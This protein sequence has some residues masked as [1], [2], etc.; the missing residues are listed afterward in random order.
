MCGFSFTVF[1]S[2]FQLLP[3]A[4]Y[5]ILELGRQ[6]GRGGDVPRLPDLRL[7]LLRAHHGL[8]GRPL[9]QA[10]DARRRAASSCPRSRPPTRSP[11]TTACCSASPSSTA[12][13]GPAC[14]PS[15]SAYITDFIPAARRAEGIGYWGLSHHLRHRL[16]A[17]PRL[18]ALPPRGLDVALRLGGHPEP[19][20]GGHRLPARGGPPRAGRPD[21]FFGRHLIEWRVLALSHDPVPVFLRLRR[22][23]QLRRPVRRREPRGAQGGL[24][25]DLRHRRVVHAPD[26]RAAGGSV[27]LPA[28]LPALPGADR[29]R[30]RAPRRSTA[31]S[32]AS[33]PPPPS[34]APASAPRTPPLPPT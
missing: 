17:D 27:R 24:L 11:A 6:Q 23:H 34:S 21:A 3:T 32:R 28:G 16:G 2:A 18:L 25:H 26:P 30:A 10:A 20:D 1:L 19:R 29:R 33:S 12:A 8:A 15:S 13:S 5:R 7:R 22:H 9:R 31:A 14:S 4:P